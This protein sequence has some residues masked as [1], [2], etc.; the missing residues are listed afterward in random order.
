MNAFQLAKSAYSPVVAPFRSAQSNEYEAFAKV[1]S[2]L[3]R[4]HT[5]AETGEAVHD[6]RALWVVL[7][8]DVCDPDN[9]LPQPLRASIFY[10][11]EFT[12]V[13]SRKVLK[14]TAKIDAL[15]DI[16]AAVMAGLRQ[17]SART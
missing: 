3:K 17:Q 6:N 12:A 13:H 7:A 2:A 11:S 15:L 5:P 8:A 10:L 9:G 16:N 1:T 4:A 14:G